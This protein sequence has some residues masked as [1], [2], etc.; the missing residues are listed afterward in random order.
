MVIHFAAVHE[1]NTW[2]K[3]SVHQTLEAAISGRDGAENLLRGFE[4]VGRNMRKAYGEVY[5]VFVWDDTMQMADALRLVPGSSHDIERV[6]VTVELIE[7]Y[8]RKHGPSLAQIDEWFHPPFPDVGTLH[9]DDIPDGV[10]YF[11]GAAVQVLVNAY[12]RNAAARQACINHYGHVCIACNLDFEVR[13]GPIGHS[14][15][16]VH[17]EVPIADIGADYKV[18]PIRDLK[19]VC[20]NCHAML[21]RQ[22][23][24]LSIE[25][26]RAILRR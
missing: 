13:Y 17:H 23:P 9:P 1:K 22:D 18:D 3:H 15:I 25:K 8:Q 7:L 10:Q 26:L 19:P 14:F 20:P 4:R 6:K 11:E 24:P 12:E 21:H 16:H 5:A 2:R